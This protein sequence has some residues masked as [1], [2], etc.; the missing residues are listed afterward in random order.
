MEKRSRRSR[1]TQENNGMT[2]IE[3]RGHKITP[4]SY[5]NSD[6][7]AHWFPLA[8]VESPDGDIKRVVLNPTGSVAIR[9]V[10]R[11]RAI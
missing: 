8:V 5:E 7:P 10:G 6:M 4:A 9:M 2:I 1:A 11:A 3:F